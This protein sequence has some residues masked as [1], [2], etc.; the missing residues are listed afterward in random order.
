VG[1]L[2]E[3]DY[4]ALWEGPTPAPTSAPRQRAV[5][6]PFIGG[7]EQQWQTMDASDTGGRGIGTRLM[8]AIVVANGVGPLQ[9]S[10]YGATLDQA[11]MRR[12]RFPQDDS[13]LAHLYTRYLQSLIQ[14]KTLVDDT[15]VFQGFR[16]LLLSFAAARWYTVARA[17]L[18]G[19]AV[20]EA[21]D[22]RQGIRM[23]EKGLGHAE[24]LRTGPT[25]WVV[26]F[27][28]GRHATPAT[29]IHNFSTGG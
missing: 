8:L 3:S 9:L 11:A 6:A 16:Y 12:V 28:F 21:D 17:A 18:A 26:R 1:R 23:V 24:G 15:D 2:G 5:L 13:A 20:A 19:R 27:L 7:L 14:R 10:G 22:L 25:Q 4:A 29:M